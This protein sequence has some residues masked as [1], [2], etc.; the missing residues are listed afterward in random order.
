MRI[1]LKGQKLTHI[2]TETKQ[3]IC[4]YCALDIIRKNSNYE[5]KELK[6][7]FDGYLSVINNIIN[8][9]QA[10]IQIIQKTLNEINKNK[11]EEIKN[12]TSYFDYIFKY[13][14]NKKK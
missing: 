8:L 13:L 11:N 9:N 3:I 2:I 1:I 6:E 5:I 7:K 12:I 14:T 10:N 4:I